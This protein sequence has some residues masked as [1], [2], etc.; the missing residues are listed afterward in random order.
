LGQ[1]ASYLRDKVPGFTYHQLNKVNGL[2]FTI[3]EIKDSIE[4][5][6]EEKQ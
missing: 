3:N 2:P 6:L 5:L 4:K 1:F